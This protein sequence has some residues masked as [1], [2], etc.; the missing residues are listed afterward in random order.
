[1]FTQ[2]NQ[3]L[4]F[5]NLNLFLKKSLKVVSPMFEN[6]SFD[7]FMFNKDSLT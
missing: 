1:M 2:I 3:I 4:I 5:L 7:E 6:G